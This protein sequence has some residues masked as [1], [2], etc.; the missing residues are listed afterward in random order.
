[1]I[2]VSFFNTVLV[3]VVKYHYKQLY[4]N[5]L[6][7]NNL[8]SFRNLIEEFHAFVIYLKCIDSNAEKQ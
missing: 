3:K 8:Y 5:V 1:L 4:V 6:I 2:L 7:F